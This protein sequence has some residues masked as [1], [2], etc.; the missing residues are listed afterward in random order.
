MFVDLGGF[1]FRFLL[2]NI[3]FC[4]PPG[5]FSRLSHKIVRSATKRA[6]E[7][8]K[9]VVPGRRKQRGVVCESAHSHG[10]GALSTGE[11][12][13]RVAPP[14]GLYKPGGCNC[15]H[16]DLRCLSFRT[17]GRTGGGSS[18]SGRPLRPSS[19]LWVHPLFPILAT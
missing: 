6:K 16:A 18:L 14:L 7:I 11:R 10:I 3:T 9:C 5:L 2:K 15:R 13:R 4:Y 8:Q 19:A 17:V 12:P 1:F